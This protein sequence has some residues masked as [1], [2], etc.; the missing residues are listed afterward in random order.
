MNEFLHHLDMEAAR[1]HQIKMPAEFLDEASQYADRYKHPLLTSYLQP[2]HTF[3]AVGRTSPQLYLGNPNYDPE[4]PTNREFI[5][6]HG[7][8]AP[9]RMSKSRLYE[10]YGITPE[11]LDDPMDHE[12]Y[13][14][15]ACRHDSPSSNAYDFFDTLKISKFLDESGEPVGYLYLEDGVCPGNDSKIVTVSNRMTLSCLQWALERR[16]YRCNFEVE[17][18]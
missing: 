12:R 14:E 7:D 15:Y 18:S 1:R 17:E 16:G 2:D 11:E 5:R 4:I 10:E 9:S 3:W 8:I 13:A 6:E